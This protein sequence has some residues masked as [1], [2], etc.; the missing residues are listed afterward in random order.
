MKSFRQLKTSSKQLAGRV[1]SKMKERRGAMLIL[2]AAMMFVF[3]AM[4][5]FTVDVAWMQLIRTEMRAST[6]SAAKAAVEALAR[7][8]SPRAA[9]NAAKR[10]ARFNKVAGKPLILTDSDIVLGRTIS[11]R[12][13]SHQFV[14]NQTPFTSA[15][16]S[17]QFAKR[18][19][20]KP[21]NLFFSHMLG[22]PTFAP[23]ETAT[24]SHLENEVMIS[25]DRSHSMCF[26][27]SGRDW[28][29]APNNPLANPRI[30]STSL[31][32][33]LAPPHPTGSR[34]SSL[35]R[36][37]NDFI[38]EANNVF[39]KPKVGLVSWGSDTFQYGIRYRASVLESQLSTIYSPITARINLLSRNTMI[40]ATNL[41]AGLDEARRHIT[42]P[43]ASSS[44][45]NK[46]IILMTDG[47]WNT[48]R[49][50]Y[51]AA[52][53]C[54][55]AGVTVHTVTFLP[56]SDQRTMREIARITGG[57]FFH[58]TNEIELRNTFRELAR[59]L[60]V[61]LTN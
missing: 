29:Y 55:A 56:G 38:V 50:P 11:R 44:S 10:F 61:V 51:S 16:V 20:N 49:H 9:K 60:P 24:A 5:A 31:R 21:V 28:R 59:S 33:Y 48:G 41:S 53:D 23:S 12:D 18:A 27:R 54:L 45:A 47:Q 22:D 57:R 39:Q 36:A 13:G 37:V 52:R 26:D 43:R 40:G 2:M 35:N 1:R 8:Q 46:T 58:A 34:W 14:P 19:R 7:Q 32:N 4:S 3:I 25:V 30:R 6:D 15:Q 42:D 17:V